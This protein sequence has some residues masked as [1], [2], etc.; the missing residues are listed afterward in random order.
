MVFRDVFS[1]DVLI[2]QFKALV[3]NTGRQAF[4]VGFL[5]IK[6]IYRC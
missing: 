6:H 1:N 4:V 5:W 3:S 2:G